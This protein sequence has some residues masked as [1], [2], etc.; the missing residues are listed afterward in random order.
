MP[1]DHLETLRAVYD[2]WAAGDFRKGQELWDEDAVFSLRPEFPDSGVY[3]GPE[4][5]ARYM[6]LFLGAWT[7]LTITAEEFVEAGDSVVVAVHQR[8]FGRE[9]DLPVELRYFQTWTFR[10]AKAIRFECIRDR[11]ELVRYAIRRGLIE[12]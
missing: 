9:S 2:G 3:H 4:G 12:P 5:V 8:G 6:R 1:R 11:V 10:G 7:Q